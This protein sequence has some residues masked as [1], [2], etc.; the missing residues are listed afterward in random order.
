M[1]NQDPLSAL[2]WM[3]SEHSDQGA[4]LDA[5]AAPD[6]ETKAARHFRSLGFVVTEPQYG[7]FSIEGPPELFEN[8]L[9]KSRELEFDK[10]QLPPEIAKTVHVIT[11]S[12][13]PAFGPPDY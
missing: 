2:V 12:E 10:S 5:P 7:Q 8:E 9:G 3:R 13:P 4:T 11:F 6:A 1:S